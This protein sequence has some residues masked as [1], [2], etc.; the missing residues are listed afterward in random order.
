MLELTGV[1]SVLRGIGFLYWLLAIG[2]LIL[3][4][5][6]G[7]DWR[8]KTLWALPVVCVFG[9]LPVTEYIEQSRSG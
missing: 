9:Y 8:G 1:A 4:I 3:A 6:K 7:K 2:L 5:R